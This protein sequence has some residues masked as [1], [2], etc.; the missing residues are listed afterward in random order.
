MK[1]IPFPLWTRPCACVCVC[2]CGVCVC[3]L[4]P[5]FEVFLKG[6]Q[7]ETQ[8]ICRGSGFWSLIRVFISEVSLTGLDPSFLRFISFF[9]VLRL[10]PIPDA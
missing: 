9:E 2:V 3:V 5:N 8:P 1:L 4:A 6:S 7:R 10:I